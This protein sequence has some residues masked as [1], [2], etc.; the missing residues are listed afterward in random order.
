MRRLALCAVAVAARFALAGP[1]G[2]ATFRGT[3]VHRNAPRLVVATHSGRMVAIRTTRA[4]RVGTVVRVSGRSIRKVGR[5]RHA[6]LRGTVTY[7]NRGRRLFTLSARGASVLIHRR[8][9][10]VARA[11]SD[12]MPASG[13]QVTVNASLDDQGDVE[14]DD[15]NEDGQDT[16]GIDLE[17]KVLSVDANARTLNLSADDDDE[18]GAAIVVHVPTSFDLTQFQTGNDVELVV[19]K[20]T[21]G[22]FTL[23][24]VDENEADNEGDDNGDN[25]DHQGNGG[26]DNGGGGDD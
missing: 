23:Q 16:N 14:A 6:R 7:V 3:I 17:V 26:D 8:T 20:E 5:T 13:S 9:A 21:D 12:D 24:K 18:S 10:R 4:I 2:A 15:V 25:N 22:T 19:T 11:A 1:A